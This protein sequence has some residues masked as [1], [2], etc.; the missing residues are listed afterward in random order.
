MTFKVIMTNFGLDK[1]WFLI[2]RFFA[3]KSFHFFWYL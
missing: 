2:V 1:F 3:T